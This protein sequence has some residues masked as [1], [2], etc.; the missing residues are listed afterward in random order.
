MRALLIA[1]ACLFLPT[2]A[3]AET[4][5]VPSGQKTQLAIH[6]RFDNRCVPARVE[7][8][9]LVAPENG[10]VT[11][12]PTDYIVP[13]VNRGGVQ[14]PPQCVGKSMR[15]VA[16]FYQSKPGFVGE[17]SF[18]Y[19]RVNADKTDDRFNAEVSYTV[20]VK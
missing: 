7:V 19:R 13:A 4:A 11:T 15:G 17:D 9:V 14:Q 20:T 3:R 2:L 18:R 12:E 6:S 1:A 10:T 8:T 5:T 16:V